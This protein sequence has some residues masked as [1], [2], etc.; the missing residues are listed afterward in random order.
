[1]SEISSPTIYSHL[2]VTDTPQAKAGEAAATPA[3]EGAS[4]LEQSEALAKKA[5]IK[6]N[7]RH[8]HTYDFRWSGE[9]DFLDMFS[10]MQKE[11]FTS[12]KIQ[13]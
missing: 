4:K 1:M 11:N 13:P 5:E 3:A 10:I 12:K 9:T 8:S 2:E 6:G 7:N